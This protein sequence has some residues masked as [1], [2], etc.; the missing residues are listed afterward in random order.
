MLYP[1]EPIKL[2]L[3]PQMFCKMKNL[4]LLTICNVHYCGRLEYLPSGLKLLDWQ[5]FPWSSLPPKFYPKNLVSLNLSH[6][7]IERP[8]KKVSSLVFINYYFFKLYH[9]FLFFFFSSTDLF[10]PNLDRSEFQ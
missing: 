8:L 7:R 10:V 5:G 9:K 2:E 4:R 6:S 1:P 3:K